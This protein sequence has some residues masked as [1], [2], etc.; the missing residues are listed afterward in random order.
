MKFY[1]IIISGSGGDV[2]IEKVNGG[3]DGRWTD[4]GQRPI[5]I[6]HLEL[7]TG[8]MNMNNNYPTTIFRSIFAQNVQI[9]GRKIYT[10]NFCLRTFQGHI[11]NC[12]Q[13][14]KYIYLGQNSPKY[15]SQIILVHVHANGFL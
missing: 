12:K 5:T 4:D 15:C 14:Q 1:E 8:C 9:S 13:Y 10:F 3:R 2:V 6:A 11:K 7:K